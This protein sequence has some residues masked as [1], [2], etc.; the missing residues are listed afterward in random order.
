VSAGC[1]GETVNVP[2]A[3]L[4]LALSRPDH[5]SPA[6]QGIEYALARRGPREPQPIAKLAHERTSSL[7]AP[8]QHGQGPSTKSELVR[9]CG[10]PA[11]SSRLLQL[12]L[13]EGCSSS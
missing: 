10:L 6:F 2:S 12:A 8:G 4:P 3:R 13:S 1:E 7:P 5:R 11:T 9:R